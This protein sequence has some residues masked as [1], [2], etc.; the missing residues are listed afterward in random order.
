MK[1]LS[2][3]QFFLIIP[4]L[5]VIFTA[6]PS[7]AGD[8]PLEISERITNGDPVAGKEKSTLC[9][10]CHGEFGISIMPEVPSLAGQWG[11]YLMRQLRDFSIGSRSDPIMSDMAATVSNYEDAFD[12]TAYFASQNQMTSTEKHKNERGER[13]YMIY[14]CISCHGEEGKGRP[15]NNPMFPVIGGQQKSYLIK[16]LDDFRAGFRETDMSGTMPILAKRM[17][18]A[19]TDAIADYLSGL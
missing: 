13:L 5:T 8:T 19:E 14:R 18:A 1:I 6:S 3:K 9:Q 15:Q 7:F 12:I 17:S 10:G 4:I 2:L 11:A 16:Q